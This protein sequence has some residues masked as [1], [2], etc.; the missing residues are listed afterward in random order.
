MHV[1]IHVRNLSLQASSR[2]ISPLSRTQIAGS[3]STSVLSV[4]LTPS[5]LSAPTSNNVRT[6]GAGPTGV[7][8]AAE[9]HDLLYTDIRKHYP[10]LFNLA[11]INL[12]DTAPT[13]LGSFDEG[14]QQFATK[15]F[16]REGINILTQHHVERVEPVCG[17][18]PRVAGTD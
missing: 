2:R 11:R 15:R 3:C 6:I 8:F 1:S 16:K 14:L 12:F 18:A 13:I 10:V 9:L 5:L 7:E 4:R 17:Y